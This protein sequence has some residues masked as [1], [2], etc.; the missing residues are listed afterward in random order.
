MIDDSSEVFRGILIWDK[1][2]PPIEF[3]SIGT[4]A[5]SNVVMPLIAVRLSWASVNSDRC[6]VFADLETLVAEE[7]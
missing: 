7:R 4:I 5:D 1:E 6:P 3:P 2:P